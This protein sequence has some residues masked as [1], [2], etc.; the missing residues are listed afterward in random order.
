M[1]RAIVL[2]L[3]LLAALAAAQSPAPEPEHW[4]GAGVGWNHHSAPQA[5]G[6]MTFGARIA[7]RIYSFSTL[8]MTSARASLRTGV[9]R[10]LSHRD[11]FTLLGIADA[12]MAAGGGDAAAAIS[13]GVAVAYDIDRWTR[14]PRSFAL[15]NVRVVKT[16]LDS[17]APVFMLG[18][19]KSL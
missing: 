8:D 17:V 15:F 1:T 2:L 12:G 3:L 16:G 9:A 18:V 11:G 6:W 4:V 14:I 13:G 10:L 7:P 19:G 5:L